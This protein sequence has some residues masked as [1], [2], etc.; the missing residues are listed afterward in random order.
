MNEIEADSTR[1]LA[2]AVKYANMSVKS[3]NNA[4]VYAKVSEQ[5]ALKVAYSNDKINELNLKILDAIE[6]IK[7]PEI[8]FDTSERYLK[9]IDDAIELMKKYQADAEEAAELVNVYKNKTTVEY[10][11]SVS[12]HERTLDY[13]ESMKSTLQTYG[14]VEPM[15]NVL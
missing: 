10:N 9:L 6:Y 11:E 15:K 8:D 4:Q 3:K 5:N 7:N 13:V 12:S 1:T 2:N 14:Y